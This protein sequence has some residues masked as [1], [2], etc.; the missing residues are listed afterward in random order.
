MKGRLKT[1]LLISGNRGFSA[2]QKKVYKAVLRIPEGETRSYRWVAERIGSPRSF[3]AVGN[4]L[5]RNPYPIIIPC[6]R[7]VRAGGSIGGYSRGVREK[8]K[9]LKKEQGRHFKTKSPITSHQTIW[10]GY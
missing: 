5:N 7:V 6:H 2:F 10:F 1:L 9:L 4:A 3:R 8:L